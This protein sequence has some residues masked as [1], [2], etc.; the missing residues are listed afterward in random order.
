MFLNFSIFDIDAT[1]DFNILFILYSLKWLQFCIAQ[2][3]S[4]L[5]FFSIISAKTFHLITIEV[6]N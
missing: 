6:K 4:K 5:N 3:Q 1:V 2:E